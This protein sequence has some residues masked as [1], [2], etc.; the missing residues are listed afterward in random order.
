MS[1][2]VDGRSA[3]RCC[4]TIVRQTSLFYGSE[5]PR[6][7]ARRLVGRVPVKVVPGAAQQGY[8]LNET[9]I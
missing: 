4:N 6:L 5:P 8:Y 9:V 7:A 2:A 1:D 3:A